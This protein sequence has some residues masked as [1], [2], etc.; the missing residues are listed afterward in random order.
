MEKFK[1]DKELLIEANSIIRSFYSIIERKGL[2]TNWNVIEKK[3]KEILKEQHEYMY[4][5]I[6][7]IRKK[8]LNKLSE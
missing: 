6:K 5:T 3:V 1:S 2:T 7:Q 4:P 8:K